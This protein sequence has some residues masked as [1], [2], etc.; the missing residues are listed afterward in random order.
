MSK[1]DKPIKI[2]VCPNCGRVLRGVEFLPNVRNLAQNVGTNYDPVAGRFLC[3]DCSY[4]GLPIEIDKDD[5][6]KIEFKKKPITPPLGK[7]N[8]TY[9]RLLLLFGFIAILIAIFGIGYLDH[10]ITILVLALLSLAV[11]YVSIGVKK[12]KEV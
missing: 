6:S 5:Y 11:I 1:S 3:P 7:G 2:K 8:P 9:F 4:S 12:F 10:S